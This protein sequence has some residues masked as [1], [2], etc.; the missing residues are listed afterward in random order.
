M[1]NDITTSRIMRYTT[2]I[3][4]FIKEKSCMTEVLKKDLKIND[5]L[6]INNNFTSIIY[7]TIVTHQMQK[8]KINH[9]H[10][11][12]IAFSISLLMVIVILQDNITYYNNIYGELVIKNLLEQIPM[13]VIKSLGK[14]FIMINEKSKRN[15]IYVETSKMYMIT[16]KRNLKDIQEYTTELVN[17]SMLKICKSEIL[18]GTNKMLKTDIL[19]YNFKNKEKAIEKYT[20]LLKININN[21]N[22]YIDNKYGKIC[23]LALILAWV[24]SGGNMKEIGVLEKMGKQLGM[25]IKITNDINNV[26][27]DLEN[28]I[29]SVSNN[30]LINYGTLKCVE[31]FYKNKEELIESA[32]ILDIFEITFDEI[33]QVLEVQFLN[34]LENTSFDID[35][36][37][38]SSISI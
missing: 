3:E 30:F 4:K 29:N 35:K 13:F 28:T 20:K 16:D 34:G 11:Y 2:S 8:N 36:S 21:M 1:N 9:E 19:D 24:I 25:L 27:R 33:I 18:I 7:L 6:K 17:N 5:I 31:L 38:Y 14:H 15:K 26:E 37:V 10:G 23:E 12:F 32:M 22:N